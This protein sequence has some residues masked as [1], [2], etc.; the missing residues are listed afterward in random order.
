MP[1]WTVA[2]LEPHREALAQRCLALAGFE[3]YLPR[4]RVVPRHAGR[5]I[6]R[7]PPLFPGYCFIAV[8]LQWHAARWCL[9]VS[10]LVMNGGKPA[11]VP[12]SIIDEIR[13]RERDGLVEVPARPPAR[14]GDP[15]RIV[16]GVFT[17]RLALYDG[18]RGPERCA[19][20]LGLLGRAVLPADHLEVV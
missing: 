13:S 17:G 2:R 7:G 12:D 3:V 9:G 11:I 10:A 19:V 15:V 4:L 6:E 20:L 5:K 14:R 16:A 1:Y 8:E 18:M